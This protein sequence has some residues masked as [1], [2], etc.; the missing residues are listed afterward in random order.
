MGYG[1]RL[2]KAMPPMQQINSEEKF[3]EAL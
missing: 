2:M 3:I 1:R